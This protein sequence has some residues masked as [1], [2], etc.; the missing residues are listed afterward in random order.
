MQLFISHDEIR[1]SHTR[2][3][4][5]NFN[6]WITKTIVNIFEISVYMRAIKKKSK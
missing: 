2:E 1:H 5:E 6:S 4:L 3:E